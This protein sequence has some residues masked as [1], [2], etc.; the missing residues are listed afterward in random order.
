MTADIPNRD[1][2]DP[3]Y[4]YVEK[5]PQL[6]GGR[7]TIQQFIDYYPYPA[8][9]LENNIEGKVILQFI[10]EKSGKLS[11]IKIVRSPDQ[12]L[13]DAAIAYIHQWPAW[14][15]AL[16]NEKPVSCLFTL[17]I[18]YNIEFYNTRPR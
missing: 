4:T 18:D 6:S 17:P 11:D 16:H 13:S 9:G 5:M 15:P 10:V 2:N 1:P 8:C 3:V 7:G 12:C 14:K